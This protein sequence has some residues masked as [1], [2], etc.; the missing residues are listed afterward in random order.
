MITYAITFT[1]IVSPQISP[2]NFGDDPI[3]YGDYVSAQCSVHKGDLPINIAWLHNNISIGYINGI[4]VTKV[5]KKSSSITIDSVNEEH[6]GTYTCLAENKAGK[7]EFST[8]LYIN[9]TQ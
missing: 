2:F 3:N 5:G 8:Y 6:T 7:A 4:Q 1:L 9:G